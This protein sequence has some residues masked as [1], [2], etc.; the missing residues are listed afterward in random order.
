[1]RN[2]FSDEVFDDV[3]G[4]VNASPVLNINSLDNQQTA[5]RP[6]IS[7]LRPVLNASPIYRLDE[8]SEIDSDSELFSDVNN[9][10][11]NTNQSNNINQLDNYEVDNNEVDDTTDEILDYSSVENSSD[12]YSLY[13][14]SSGD[15]TEDLQ[16]DTIDNVTTILN[17]LDNS[18]NEEIIIQS[19]VDDQDIIIT[20]DSD[21]LRLKMTINDIGKNV[22]NEMLAH[23]VSKPIVTAKYVYTNETVVEVLSVISHRKE[24]LAM[25]K[26][27]RVDFIPENFS[28]IIYNYIRNNRQRRPIV[29]AKYYFSSRDF[30]IGIIKTGIRTDIQYIPASQNMSVLRSMSMHTT[31]EIQIIPD[32]QSVIGP[33]SPLQASESN[34]ISNTVASLITDTF[35]EILSS[36]LAFQQADYHEYMRSSQR[37]GLQPNTRRSRASTLSSELCS[38]VLWSECSTLIAE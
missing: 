8:N 14:P 27:F 20:P 13:E 38:S 24:L 34:Y 35:S 6:S 11:N 1:M 4:D 7:V 18:S 15:Y 3:F 31:S 17:D 23:I 28:N 21:V 32:S 36:P 22:Y 10:R 19:P 12:R 25:A 9:Q 37:T 2:Y 33:S 16:I 26:V 5:R 30:I 29:T